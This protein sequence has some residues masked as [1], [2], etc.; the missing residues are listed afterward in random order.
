VHDGFDWFEESTTAGLTRLPRPDPEPTESGWRFDRAGSTWN[1]NAGTGRIGFQSQSPAIIV[2]DNAP[3]HAIYWTDGTDAQLGSYVDDVF[4]ADGEAIPANLVLRVKPSAD[5]IFEGGIPALPRLQPGR[6]HW[7][8]LTREEETPPTPTAFP[9]WTRE[10]RLLSPPQEHDAPFEGR[11]LSESERAMLDKVFSYNPAARV[12][13]AWQ[14]HAPFS[15]T[16]RLDKP[17]PDET[18]PGAVLDRIQDATNRVRPA[19]AHVRLAFGEQI[20]RGDDNG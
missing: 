2:S 15:I 6:G 20:M 8:Y 4:V 16:V 10:G 14:P 7:R 5:Q 18:L 1:Y 3:V 11:F 13:F 19:G 9:A 12:R 17:I